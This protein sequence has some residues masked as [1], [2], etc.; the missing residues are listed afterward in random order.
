MFEWDDGSAV[1]HNKNM[2]LSQFTID[3]IT[4][5][6]CHRDYEG[7]YF[8]KKCSNIASKHAFFGAR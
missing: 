7:M 3:N 6:K 4:F 2:E 5:G 1:T 8:R